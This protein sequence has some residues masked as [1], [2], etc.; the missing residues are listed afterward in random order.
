VRAQQEEAN[1]AIAS[2]DPEQ[3]EAFVVSQAESAPT[4]VAA[5]PEVIADDVAAV[6]EWQL[7][8]QSDALEAHGWDPA[9]LMLDGSPQDRYDFNL[10]DEEIREEFARVAAYEQQVCGA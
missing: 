10:T 9:A 3:I 5:A 4:I 1:G 6:S 8:E 7:N 2:G